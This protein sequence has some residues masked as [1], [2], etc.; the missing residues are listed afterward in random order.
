MGTTVR[1]VVVVSTV[2]TVVVTVLAALVTALSTAG[3]VVLAVAAIALD[4]ALVVNPAGRV[5]VE[6]GTV[7]RIIWEGFKKAWPILVSLAVAITKLSLMAIGAW[8]VGVG[9]AVNRIRDKAIE[10]AGLSGVP[11][12]WDNIILHGATVLTV[13]ECD[14]VGSAGLPHYRVHRVDS[15][16]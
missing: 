6:G 14:R 3:I 11:S 5:G 2:A 8:T 9:T 10:Q 7:A 4:P 1:V 13:V 12:E 16:R 15:L